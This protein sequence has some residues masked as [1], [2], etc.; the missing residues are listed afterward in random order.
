MTIRGV[1]IACAEPLFATPELL[2]EQQKEEFT[3]KWRQ[4]HAL[5]YFKKQK[6]ENERK[7]REEKKEEEGKEASQGEEENTS[8]LD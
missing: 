1:A 3:E 6:E 7:E 2:T 8:K 4:W 5:N